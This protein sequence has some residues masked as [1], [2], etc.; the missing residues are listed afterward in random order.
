MNMKKPKVMLS[1]FGGGDHRIIRKE[2][3]IRVKN[4]YTGETINTKAA[5]EKEIRKKMGIG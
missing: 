1:I 5:H 3:V 4:M 2:T